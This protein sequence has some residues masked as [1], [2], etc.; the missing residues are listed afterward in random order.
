MTIQTIS[1]NAGGI[2]VLGQFYKLTSEAI[3]HHCQPPAS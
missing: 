3:L 2:A 1:V